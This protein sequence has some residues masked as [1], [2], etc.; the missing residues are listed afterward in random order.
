MDTDEG[1][2]NLVRSP[3]APPT[4]GPGEERSGSKREGRRRHPAAA[5]SRPAIPESCHQA[6]LLSVS[7]GTFVPGPS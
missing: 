5:S 3:P 2:V 4:Y 1:K 7:Y 6:G